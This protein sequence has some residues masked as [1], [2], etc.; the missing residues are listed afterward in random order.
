MKTVFAA[1]TLLTASLSLVLSSA[2]I[3]QSLS[4][5]TI[6]VNASGEST[7]A[8]T[9]QA[10]QVSKVHYRNSDFM[11]VA[12]LAPLPSPVPQ[13][14][15]P[16]AQLSVRP[17]ITPLTSPSPGRVTTPTPVRPQIKRETPA[18]IA[19]APVA[20]TT[21]TRPT[22]KPNLTQ[23]TKTQT[24]T[25]TTP[26]LVKPASVKPVVVPPPPATRIITH[27]PSKNKDGSDA[28]NI[29][30]T[31][32]DGPSPEYTPQVLAL[33]K[34]H[35][36]KAT[37]CVVGRQVKKHPE[38]IQQIV[39]E[40]HKVANHSMNHD[41]NL[42]CR[43]DEKLKQEV[44]AEKALIESVVPG[45]SV[46]YFRAPAGNWNLHMRKVIL[47]WGMKPLGWSIDTKDWQQPGTEAIVNMV[48]NR[49]HSGAVILMHD[50]GGNRSQSVAALKQFLPTLKESGY[51]F[52][53]PQ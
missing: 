16:S 32:D 53:L 29:S 4:P 47:A 40:G 21:I 15:V 33:L 46:D 13:K 25:T 5:S 2:S 11:L 27:V 43:S 51:N 45:V 1:A 23:T 26:A 7:D 10:V 8:T 19:V 34:K 50:G 36:I 20:T 28:K 38:L 24:K 39:A 42:P 31:F 12:Q 41:E 30:L 35:G 18:S 37:F 9:P 44:L 3:G 6:D 14:A 17:F 22:I 48:N 49:I 52:V